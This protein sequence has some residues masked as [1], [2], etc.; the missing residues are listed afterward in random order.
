MDVGV[1]LQRGFAG[2]PTE[3]TLAASAAERLGYHSLWINDHITVPVEIQS[4]YP[5]S[6]D[7]RPTMR[8]D[9]PYSDALATLAF[10][11][12]ITTR[13]RLGT[14]VLPMIT[15][16]PLTLAKQA[17]TVDRLSGGR[18]ELGLGAGWLTEEAEAIGHPHDHRGQ[19]LDEAID[20]MRKAWS[21]PSFEHQ[22]RFWQIKAT[23][24]HP[25]PVQGADVPIWIGGSSPAAF[26]TTASRGVGNLFWVPEADQLRQLGGRLRQLRPDLKVGASLR[27]EDAGAGERAQALRDAG[28]DL[29]LLISH[30]TAEA[31]VAELETFSAKVAP[32]L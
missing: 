9:T 19:R 32:I 3:L 29:L 15:R 4:R 21:Q 10:L 16:D 13:V 14:S 20:I 22:G 25:Q 8:H 24:V 7:G 28:A 12:A 31:L 11:A 1:V 18:L 6:P 2:S 30:T 26:R 27:L 23:G 17:A 5:Y